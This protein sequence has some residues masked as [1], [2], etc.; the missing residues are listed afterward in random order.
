MTPTDVQVARA[1]AVDVAARVL[2]G[3]ESPLVAAPELSRLRFSVGIRD[4]DADFLAFVGVDSESDAPPIGQARKNWAPAALAEEAE[5]IARAEKWA[6][7]F[8]GEAF[9]NIVHRFG[10]AA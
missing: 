9:R 6:L 7:D 4:D 8:A 3:L 2:E 5:E 1:R 10:G